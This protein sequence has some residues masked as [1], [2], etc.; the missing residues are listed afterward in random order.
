M[1]AFTSS[2]LSRYTGKWLIATGIFELALA[3]VFLVA[4]L[5]DAELTFGFGLTALILGVTGI[6]LIFSGCVP[7]G[8]RPKPTGS[9]ALV[10]P[11]QRP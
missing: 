1:P 3:A 10:S 5:A 4:G 11:G 7:A 9:R 8:R 6:G 2:T